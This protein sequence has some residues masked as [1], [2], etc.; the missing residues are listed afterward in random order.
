[1]GQSI[2]GTDLPNGCLQVGK[3]QKVCSLLLGGRRAVE[4]SRAR[5]GSAFEQLRK[6]EKDPIGL[7]LH[8]ENPGLK[9]YYPQLYTRL[10]AKRGDWS[11][12]VLGALETEQ[13]RIGAGMRWMMQLWR[14]ARRRRVSYSEPPPRVM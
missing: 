6:G 4:A 3:L 14:R 5:S 10:A 12:D 13:A 9:E 2:S 1:M 8:S 7:V 11:F